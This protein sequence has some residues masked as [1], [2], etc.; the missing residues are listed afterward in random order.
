MRVA[1]T[2][3]SGLIGGR[4]VAE[5][6]D[7]GD[8]VVALSR[9]PGLGAVVWD[10]LT[11]PAPAEALA[12]CDAVVHL[13][14]ENIAQ[15]WTAAAKERIRASREL[16]TRNLVAGLR[17]AEPRPAALVHASGGDYYALR[18][19]E[20]VD[21]SGP[22]GDGYLAQVCVAWEREASAAKPL[23]VRVT[24]VRT[25]PVLHRSGGALQRM[26]V[27]FR[28]GL[29]GPVAGGRQWFPW[30]ALDDIA[31]IYVAALRGGEAWAGPVNACA[32]E[33]VRNA[34]F[35]KALGRALHRPA[36]LPVPGLALKA[37]YGDMAQIVTGG[38]R[39]V[40]GRAT[41]LGYR[42]RHPELDEALRS[43]LG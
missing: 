32:P 11:G 8:D 42:F 13:A 25:G 34:D 29:G 43:A 23:G 20:R 7:R 36:V 22:P 37:L 31:G 2:G 16:G 39:M 12:G 17:A 10:P 28:L 26:L 24:H 9:S 27:P 18:G 41:E 1:V 5:L 6:R 19:D 15:R 14:G 40:P 35:A 3:A 4:L 33:P 21:E 30:I 38:V